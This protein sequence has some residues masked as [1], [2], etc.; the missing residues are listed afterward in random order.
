MQLRRASWL[1]RLTCLTLP[2]AAL[3]WQTGTPPSG[4]H[5][6]AAFT[7]PFAGAAWQSVVRGRLPNGL[8]YAVLSRRSNEPGVGLLMRVEGGFIAER[9]PGERGLTHLIEH[10]A[11][12]SPTRSAPKELRRF[13]RI[14]L[15]L[16]FQA[17][18][19]GS[20]SERET[21]L[22]FSTRSTRA[23]DLDTMLTLLRGV[24]GE[25]TLRADAVDEQRADV[26]REMATRKLGNIIHASYIAAVAPGSPYDVTDGQNHDDVPTASI[27][28]I[29]AL[30]QRLYRPENMMVV[31]VGNVD[32][33]KMKALIRQRFG[34]WRGVGPAPTR[35]SAPTFRSDRIAPISHSDWSQGRMIATMSVAMPTPAPPA[36]RRLQMQ[37]M[38]M[39]MVAVRA[40]NGRLAQP[41]APPGK[42]GLFIENGEYGHRLF[43]L[44]DNVAPGQWRSGVIGLKRTTCALKTEG[45]S[46]SAWAI[47]RQGVIQDLEQRSANMMAAPN[48]E[49]A[50]DLSHAIADGRD[51][52]PPD[53]LLRHARVWLP[54]VGEKTGNDW[55]R[56]QWRAGVE[57]V[58][59]ESPELARIGEPQAAIRAA[60]AEAVSSNDSCKLR[61]S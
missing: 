8:R 13:L 18:T 15:P 30:Y 37:S 57:H 26:M 38:L 45:L 48:V 56:R 17:P 25:M 60:L 55:W 22:F 9:R 44:W 28:T 51:L 50:K 10:L 54:T 32:P 19:A 5:K 7:A 24:A 21:N 58:R 34:D 35:V 33:A 2:A 40:V 29:R 20:N 14:G 39:D 36:T 27:E 41:G 31:I 11:L 4:S 61:S 52:V 47:A 12:I 16:T 43:L 3:A 23:A 46:P 53:E 6:V 49:L 42:T 1:L 59:V